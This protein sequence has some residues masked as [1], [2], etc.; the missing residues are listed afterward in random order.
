MKATI[1]YILAAVILAFATQAYAGGVTVYE[2]GD[3]KLKLEALF[4]LNTYQ[5]TDDRTT[6]GVSSKTKT[7]GLNVDRAYFTAKYYFNKEWMMR[8]TTDMQHQSNLSKDQNI[9]LKYAYVEGKLVDDAVVLRL[10]QSYTPWIDYEQGLWK[11]RYVAKVM[12]DQ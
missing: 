6:A 1:N 8:F 4:Y 11:H 12:S 5:Q 2:D 9:Y 3:S 10:G 7:T